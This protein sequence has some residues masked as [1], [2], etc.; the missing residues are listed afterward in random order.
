MNC[1]ILFLLNLYVP[2]FTWQ[3]CNSYGWDDTISIDL[4]KQ[5]DSYGS[6]RD[7]LTLPYVIFEFMLF[8]L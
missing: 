6:N 5:L 2:I 7:S 3:N 1:K 8:F 4:H